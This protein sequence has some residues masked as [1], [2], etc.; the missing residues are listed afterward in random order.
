M[1]LPIEDQRPGDE[2]FEAIKPYVEQIKASVPTLKDAVTQLLIED[3]STDLALS[4]SVDQVGAILEYLIQ[5]LGIERPKFDA[6][7]LL[8]H[9][10]KI[11]KLAT[12]YK[13]TNLFALPEE[14]QKNILRAEME[15]LWF[16]PNRVPQVSQM[17]LTEPVET[18]LAPEISHLLA[19]ITRMLG[20]K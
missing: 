9:L 7:E 3:M 20:K 5:D 11:T 18:K 16:D 17:K 19:T 12:A 4:E 15:R 8:R 10:G 13:M 6:D 1:T 14:L 2:I